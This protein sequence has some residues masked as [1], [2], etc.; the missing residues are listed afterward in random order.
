MP[1]DKGFTRYYW[2][3]KRRCLWTLGLVTIK[4]KRNDRHLTFTPDKIAM[5]HEMIDRCDEHLNKAKKEFYESIKDNAF[6]DD[7]T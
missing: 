7:E 6:E 5:L 1:D 4:G 2:H 3:L